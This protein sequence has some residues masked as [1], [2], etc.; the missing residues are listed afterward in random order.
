MRTRWHV[1]G[2]WPAL[3]TN[4][5]VACVDS[6]FN[7]LVD[8][9]ISHQPDKSV[10]KKT[11]ISDHYTSFGISEHY[12]LFVNGLEQHLMDTFGHDAPS[13]SY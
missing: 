13:L 1:E 3:A 11:G 4:P 7:G 10:K 2:T 6:R 12:T 8:L 5:K 9:S